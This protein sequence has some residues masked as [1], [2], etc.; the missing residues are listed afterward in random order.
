DLDLVAALLVEAD[1]RTHQGGDALELVLAALLVDHL[2]FFVLA[3]GAVDQHRDRDAVDPSGF[4]HFGLGGV[5]NLVVVGFFGLLALVL[6]ARRRPV[7]PL[8]AWQFVVNGDLA[9]IVG[10][11]GGFLPGLARTQHTAFR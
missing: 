11:G 2:A 10:G 6:G 3:V 1:R 4:S 8:V 9:V 5:G 7:R